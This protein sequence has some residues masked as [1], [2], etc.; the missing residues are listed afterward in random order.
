MTYK[1]TLSLLMAATLLVACSD[2]P[3]ERHIEQALQKQYNDLYPSLIDIQDVKKLNGWSDN[4]NHYAAEVSYTLEFNKSYQ[5]YLE[6]KTDQPGN[7]LEKI[8]SGI[9]V[10]LLKLQYGDFKKKDQYQIKDETLTF[11]MT[12]NGWVLV[13]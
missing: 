10:G 5:Q 2:I 1:T 7:P 11:R 8:T 9:S 6:E 12:E 3:S 13:D 4:D